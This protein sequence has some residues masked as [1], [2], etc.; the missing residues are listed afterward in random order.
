MIFFFSNIFPRIQNLKK[1][2]KN[3]EIYVE[4]FPAKTRFTFSDRRRLEIFP[5]N[6]LCKFIE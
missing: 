2:K 1:K 3:E 4:K 5:Y 6:I